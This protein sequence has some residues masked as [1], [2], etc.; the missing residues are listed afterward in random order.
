MRRN[1]D[2]CIKLSTNKITLK[3]LHQL[4]NLFPEMSAYEFN[5]LVADIEKHGQRVEVDLW[6]GE[7]IDGKHRAVACQKLG[8]EPRYH[9]RRFESEIGARDYAVSQN[10]HRRHLDP[11]HKRILI[12]AFADWSKSDRAIAEQ[13]KT[14]KDTI[15]RVR[16]AVEKKKAATGAP[17]PVEKKRTGKDGKVRKQPAKKQ[18]VAA[19]PEP[20][21]VEPK[22]EP[23]PVDRR[24]GLLNRAREAISLAQFDDLHGLP[25]DQEMCRIAQAAAT[26]WLEV[27][28]ILTSRKPAA[29][30][31]VET[32]APKPE[33]SCGANPFVPADDDFVSR[34]VTGA[35]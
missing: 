24:Q 16:N 17:A 34:F 26:A 6:N 31:K 13:L 25:A 23:K 7:I 22:V 33:A 21:P 27:A 3:P 11:E 15:R 18:K 30:A 1:G 20:E 28:R 19:K 10:F 14:S 9:A 5:E 8:I 29:E 35:A 4:A 2:R 32:P 12:A